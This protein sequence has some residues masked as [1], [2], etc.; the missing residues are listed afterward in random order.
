MDVVRLP[1][2]DEPFISQTTSLAGEAFRIDYHWIS[3]TDLWTI[4]IYD[5]DDTPV[6]EGAVLVPNLNLLRA[7]AGDR[8][9]Q[10]ELM[11]FSREAP[12]LESI[13]DATL[14]FLAETDF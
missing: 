3:R 14:V 5:A 8:T 11:L 9:P 2:P 7:A 4:S 1:T 12:T 6:L 13:A 10:G